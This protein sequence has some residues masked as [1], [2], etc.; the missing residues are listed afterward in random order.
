MNQSP[1]LSAMG[2]ERHARKIPWRPRLNGEIL[3]Q[4][5]EMATWPRRLRALHD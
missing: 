3:F 5:D 2:Y 1:P 4:I